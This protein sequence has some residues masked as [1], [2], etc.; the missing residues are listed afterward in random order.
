MPALSEYSNVD[1]TAF[2]VIRRKGF[3]VWYNEEETAFYA[4]K[5]GGDLRADSPCALLGLVAIYEHV[6]PT[7]FEA[8][9]WRVHD[10]VELSRVQP[11]YT[12]VWKKPPEK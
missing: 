1:R 12:P 5:D 8:Y 10:D 9:W 2:S 11:D 7:T 6:K 4:E 3:R